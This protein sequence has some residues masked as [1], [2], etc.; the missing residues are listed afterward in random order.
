M[1]IEYSTENLKVFCVSSTAFHKLNGSLRYEYGELLPFDT[2]E[3]T[4]LPAVQRY[5]I[6]LTSVENEILVDKLIARWNI[7]RPKV[8]LWAK[9]RDADIKL[10]L[11]K[12]DKLREALIG[13][14]QTFNGS[15]DNTVTKTIASVKTVLTKKI[16]QNLTEID[17]GD[18]KRATINSEE[19]GEPQMR[20]PTIKATFRRDGYFPRKKKKTIN[21]N[22][23]FAALFMQ[24]IAPLWHEMFQKT[25]LEHYKKFEVEI[26]K[27]MKKFKESFEQSMLKICSSSYYPAQKLLDQIELL[28]PLFKD[29]VAD[30]LRDFRRAATA[31]HQAIEPK[32]KELMKTAYNDCLKHTGKFI[33]T[34]IDHFTAFQL[35]LL[36][37]HNRT[38][39]ERLNGEGTR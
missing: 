15:C 4:M 3:G 10:P 17:V 28:E 32:M 12:T 27:H 29:S 38:G 5:L 2:I 23:A 25:M 16:T 26:T 21:L 1:I 13:C 39:Y 22:G 33:L 8:Q 9:M 18:W 11:D 34:C 14:L 36:I 6:S 37:Q 31:T 19:Y 30:A 7:L 20:V 35:Q 24:R